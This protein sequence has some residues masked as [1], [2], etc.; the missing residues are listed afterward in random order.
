MAEV[1]NPGHDGAVQANRQLVLTAV[2]SIA[3]AVAACTEGWHPN[4]AGLLVL[5]AVPLIAV[6]LLDRRTVV[7]L[8]AT[9]VVLAF[10]LP[11]S[12]WATSTVH[13]VRL[14]G[15]TATCAATAA[16]SF[17][18]ERLATT[19]DLYEGVGRSATDWLLRG[20]GQSLIYDPR[21]IVGGPAGPVG[22][23]ERAASL[24]EV[25]RFDGEALEIALEQNDLQRAQWLAR[26]LLGTWVEVVNLLGP[27]A[28]STSR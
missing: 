26:G 28:I 15:V 25:A 9:C 23:R 5:V 19:R 17:W 12:L 18:R 21:E 24:V 6:V 3:V 4:R 10:V 8:S 16:A 2:L 20:W 27:S 11:G 22:Q 13:F 7:T 14:S 1:R